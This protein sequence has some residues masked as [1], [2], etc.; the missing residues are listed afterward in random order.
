MFTI[1]CRVKLDCRGSV[2]LE[3]LVLNIYNYF[4]LYRPL[5][6]RYM[7]EL[8]YGEGDQVYVHD[9]FDD[10]IEDPDNSVV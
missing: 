4:D 5:K 8:E 2:K 6:R 10:S 1:Q 9:S 7:L 3:F